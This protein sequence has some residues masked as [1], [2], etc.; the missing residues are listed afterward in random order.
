VDPSGSRVRSYAYWLGVD[1]PASTVR[2]LFNTSGTVT[3]R[4]DYDPFGRQLTASGTLTNPLGFA[5]RE[6]DAM[7]WEMEL[8]LPRRVGAPL[9][10]RTDTRVG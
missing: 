2:G 6:L 5:G 7:S 10:R 3:H 1:Q 4:Y 9:E 8:Q